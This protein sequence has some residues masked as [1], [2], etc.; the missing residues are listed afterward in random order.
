MSQNSQKRAGFF[1][2]CFI[3]FSLQVLCYW[4]ALLQ[5][6]LKTHLQMSFK[7]ILCKAM[8]FPLFWCLL[9][10]LPSLLIALRVSNTCL[11]ALKFWDAACMAQNPGTTLQMS[12]SVSLS[13]IK[14]EISSVVYAVSHLV[15]YASGITDSIAALPPRKNKNTANTQVRSFSLMLSK[16]STTPRLEEQPVLKCSNLSP[17]S[18]CGEGHQK[19]LLFQKK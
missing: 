12:W 5:I 11:M 6:Q 14:Y 16:Y 8:G 2:C 1:C 9:G 10:I 13:K 4:G 19:C 3:L 15:S 7:Y 18:S 17:G